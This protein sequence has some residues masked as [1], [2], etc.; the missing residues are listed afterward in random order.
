MTSKILSSFKDFKID[1]ADSRQ[2]IDDLNIYKNNYTKI[3][4][5]RTSTII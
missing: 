3:N 5:K 1:L 2:I 4:K